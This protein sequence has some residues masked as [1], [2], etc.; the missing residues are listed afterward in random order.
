VIHGANDPR[1]PVA[2]ADQLVSAIRAHGGT[3]EYLRFRDEGHGLRKT[4][5]RVLAYRRIAAFLLRELAAAAPE[6]TR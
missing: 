1:D 3:V 6:N 5:V 4:S 2:E